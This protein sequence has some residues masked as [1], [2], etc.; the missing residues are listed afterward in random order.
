MKFLEDLRDTLKGEE[1]WVSGSGASVDDFP[2]DFFKDKICIGVNWVFFVFLDTGDGIKKFTPPRVLYSVNSHRE[3][4]DWIAKHTPHF[5]KNCFFLSHP[6]VPY[7]RNYTCWQDFNEDPYWIRNSGDHRHTKPSEAD[8]EKMAKCIMEKR[9]DCEYFCR[10][11]SLH[12]AIEVAI[13]LG[14]KK[15]YVIGGEGKGSHMQK[16]GSMYKPVNYNVPLWVSGTRSLARIF[17]KY[18]IQIVFYYYG[19]GEQN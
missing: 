3:A 8:F 17:K 14:A 10:S 15:I 6:L 18:G 7:R 11:T 19:K 2:D 5:L 12:W 16:H 9:D 4:A 13:V 1:I